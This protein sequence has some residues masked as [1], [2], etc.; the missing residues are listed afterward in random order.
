MEKNLPQP[1]RT[2]DAV[3]VR[4]LMTPDEAR[5]CIEEIKGHLIGVRKLL[6]ELEERRGWEALGYESMRQCMVGEFG[7]SQSQLY[8]ELKAG[9]IERKISPRGE[10]GLIPEGHLRHIGKLSPEKWLDAWSEVEKTAPQ[11]GVTMSHVA[12]TVAKIKSLDVAKSEQ[13]FVLGE[14]VRVKTRRRSSNWDEMRGVVAKVEE[15][16]ITIRLDDDS[17]QLLRFYRDEL[18]KINAP[19]RELN[20]I[21]EEA[22]Q[23][24][25]IVT[26]DCPTDAEFSQRMYNGC[27]GTISKRSASRRA[28]SGV[29]SLEV[30]VKG[31]IIKFMKSDVKPVNNPTPTFREIIEKVNQLLSRDDI[32]ELD[33]QILEF[34]VGRLSFTDKQL[35]RLK[36]IWD[37]YSK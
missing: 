24:G 16:E 23:C 15:Y 4:S 35:E 11:K 28:S 27:W 33:R 25:D 13:E 29:G 31:K 36:Q 7:R 37:S 18:V 1:E 3:V 10:I 6:L 34:Y 22:I 8:R 12:K 9:K 30:V 32:D 5:Q 20:Q 17:G 26:I 21:I 2:V 19:N 14:W